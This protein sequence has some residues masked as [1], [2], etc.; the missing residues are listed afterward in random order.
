MD[1]EYFWSDEAKNRKSGGLLNDTAR[2]F[3]G[4]PGVIGMYAGLPADSQLPVVQASI[5]E[6]MSGTLI[7]LTGSITTAQ[8]YTAKG[9][10]PMLK[11]AKDLVSITHS[12]PCEWET[13][14]TNGATH[15]LDLVSSTLIDPGDTI[16]VEEFSYSHALGTCFLPKQCKLL[17]V[18]MDQQG[19]RADSLREVLQATRESGARF[20]RIL[21]TIPNGQNP[22]GA[23]MSLARKKAIYEVCQEFNLLIVEDDAYFWLQWPRGEKQPPGLHQLSTGFLALDVDARVV[24][25]DTL[26]KVMGPGYRVGW[27]TCHPKLAQKISMAPTGSI[28]GF[29]SFTQVAVSKLFDAWGMDG[30]N[31]FLSRLQRSY[32]H[33]AAVAEVAARQHLAALAE[34]QPVA[35]GMFMWVKFT[36]VPD[37]EVVVTRM[38]EQ[39]RVLLPP[40]RGFW[41]AAREGSAATAPCPYIRIAFCDNSDEDIDKAFSSLALVLKELAAEQAVAEPLTS[42]NSLL[43]A[44]Q[45]AAAVEGGWARGDDKGAGDQGLKVAAAALV[46]ASNGCACTAPAKAPPT[47]VAVVTAAP[48]AGCCG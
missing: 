19:L 39:H 26:A 38:A 13:V 32:G 14:L 31:A 34:W 35:A 36:G 3:L 20:P 43:T 8:Q 47:M 18:P 7:D 45:A 16:V 4:T 21:Y 12:P 22:T 17:P 27:V 23:V 29:S 9:Y 37:A 48:A 5:V 2:K 28:F 11:W 24:R 25:I 15:A 46:A 33:K 6:A 40:G 44:A 1:Y 41:S 10:L 42:P 30:F